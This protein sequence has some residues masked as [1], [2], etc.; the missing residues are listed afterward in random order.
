MNTR[1]AHIPTPDLNDLC[2]R[3]QGAYSVSDN[4]Y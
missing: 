2:E 3:P 1:K 4:Q